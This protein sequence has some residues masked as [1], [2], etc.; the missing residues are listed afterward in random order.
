MT[1]LNTGLESPTLYLSAMKAEI[2]SIEKLASVEYFGGAN[3]EVLDDKGTTER[4]FRE[5]ERRGNR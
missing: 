4:K 2:P 1:I 3:V 5:E